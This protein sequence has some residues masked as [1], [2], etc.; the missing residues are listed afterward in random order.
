MEEARTLSSKD[1]PA[2]TYSLVFENV[3]D[4]GIWAKLFTA[5][6]MKVKMKKS[7]RRQH[8]KLPPS[9]DDP[10]LPPSRFSAPFDLPD[11]LPARLRSI[12]EHG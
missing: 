4:V 2:K 9:R 6:R 7:Y 12:G 1:L 8:M 10:P 11:W 3:G 5:T